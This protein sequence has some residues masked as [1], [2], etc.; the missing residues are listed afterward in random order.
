MADERAHRALVRVQGLLGP[1]SVF[2]AVLGGGRS[3]GDRVRLVPWGDERSPAKAPEPPWPGRL[4]AP[5][6][7]TVLAEPAPMTVWT[8]DGVPLTVDAR[9]A[10]TGPPASVRVGREPPVGVTVWAGPW[11]AEERWWAPEEASQLVRFQ[12]CLADGTTLLV[13][14]QEERWTVEAIYD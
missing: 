11:P 8:A 3:Y 4:P 6:P 7:A 12:L 13:A 14:L 2:T 9:L 1:E 5:A 10:M